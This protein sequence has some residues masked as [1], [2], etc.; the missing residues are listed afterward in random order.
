MLN[1]FF[2]LAFFCKCTVGQYP[3]TVNFC[4]I[5]HLLKI[6]FVFSKKLNFSNLKD[7]DLFGVLLNKRP[8]QLTHPYKML[9]LN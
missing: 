6:R 5:L 9:K 1:Q 3:S 8:K 2:L 4:K 7:W